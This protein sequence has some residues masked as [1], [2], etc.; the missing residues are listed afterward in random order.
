MG[1]ELDAPKQDLIDT[2]RD[3]IAALLFRNPNDPFTHT[4]THRVHVW[5]GGKEV[6]VEDREIEITVEGRALRRMQ[7]Y[8]LFQLWS[9]MVGLVGVE[10]ANFWTF[11]IEPKLLES[12][13]I[14]SD[15][16]K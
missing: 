2:T 10:Q 3:Q 9:R 14:Y 1:V 15:G 16:K 4:E 11:G 6:R 8:G 7:A 13:T 12:G 5:K